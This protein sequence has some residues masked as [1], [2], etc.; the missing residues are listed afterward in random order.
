MSYVILTSKPGQFRTE[1]GPGLTVVETWDYSAGG[2]LRARFAIARLDAATRVS[3]I[4]DDA[5]Q[6]VNSIPSRLLPRHASVQA[7]RTELG[8]L[9]R[10]GCDAK[11]E[12]SPL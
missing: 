4:D 6:A 5:P 3:V 1:P 9:A 10:G 12:P 2:R 11:L 7:A 8:Q